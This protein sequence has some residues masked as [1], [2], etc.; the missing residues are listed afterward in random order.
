MTIK[1]TCYCSS[2][3]TECHHGLFFLQPCPCLCLLGPNKEKII[4][5]LLKFDLNHPQI[6]A[7]PLLRG[8]MAFIL[9]L[10]GINTSKGGEGYDIPSPASYLKLEKD[11]SCTLL[12]IHQITK[13]SPDIDYAY[14]RSLLFEHAINVF[15][16]A[17]LIST[18]KQFTMSISC[19][20]LAPGQ[21]VLLQ[22][23][24]L[25]N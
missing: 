5:R 18:T 19:P 20:W 6:K 11:T 13:P 4:T 9:E 23:P 8:D 7:L 1:W 14:V 22:M 16:P 24:K 15:L 2:Y 12:E 25:A 21:T 10:Q 17:S 3:S